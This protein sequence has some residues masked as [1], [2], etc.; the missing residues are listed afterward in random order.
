MFDEEKN[1][2]K[3]IAEAS[4]AI[5]QKHRL[6]KVGRHTAEEAAQEFFKPM[7]KPLE[8]IV[9]H[10]NRIEELQMKGEILDNFNNDTNIKEE[11]LNEKEDVLKDLWKKSFKKETND[12]LNDSFQSAIDEEDADKL[13]TKMENFWTPKNENP[14]NNH[15]EIERDIQNVAAEVVPEGKIDTEKSK[16]NTLL[17][18]YLLK[19]ANKTSDMDLKTG[20]RPLQIGNRIG[21]TDVSFEG[22]NINVHDKKYFITEGLL[23]LIFK[24]DPKRE[25]IRSDDLETY[26]NIIVD[27][28]ACKKQYMPNNGIRNDNTAKFRNIIKPLLSTKGDGLLPMYKFERR[29]KI[30]Y[31][32]WDDPN[33]LVERLRLLISAQAAG[34]THHS[35]EIISIIEELRESKII[36]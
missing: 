31:V 19:S 15:P 17:Q 16:I 10:N 27:T 25:L 24:K 1:L 12:T 26:K 5:R 35:N 11:L 28:N 2:L 30:D 33:E 18:E 34:N 7:T 21:N 8:K 13:E 36:Y 23:E 3:R 29:E 14:V 22:N 6:L 4:K 20:V 32:Y 9:Q